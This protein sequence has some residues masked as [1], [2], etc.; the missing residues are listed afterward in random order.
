MR[1]AEEA[2][3]KEQLGQAGH[4]DRSDKMMDGEQR[5]RAKFG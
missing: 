5:V 1:S 3:L 4:R 2:L